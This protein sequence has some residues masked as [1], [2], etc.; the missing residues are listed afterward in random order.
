MTAPLKLSFR[1]EVRNLLL[2]REK[3]DHAT[4][5]P[6]FRYVNNVIAHEKQ[7]I[8]TSARDEDLTH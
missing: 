6:A 2:A 1:T 7:I 3:R 8:R 4:S 5:G